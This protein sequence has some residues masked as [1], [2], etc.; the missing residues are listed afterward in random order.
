MSFGKP[1]IALLILATIIL[2]ITGCL[3]SQSPTPT[4]TTSTDATL[5][6]T[7][8]NTNIPSLTNLSSTPIITSPVFP[9]PTTT[10][11]YQAPAIIDKNS[12][13]Q[14]VRVNL[15]KFTGSIFSPN[16]IIMVNNVQATVNNDGSYYA[17]LDLAPGE[18]S[19]EVKT[20]ANQTIA[21]DHIT[22]TFR[23]PLVIILYWAS[24]NPSDSNNYTKVPMEINGIVSDPTA[25]VEINH[26]S[27]IV[28]TDGTF[29]IQTL[30]K[31]GYNPF[32][33]VAVLG[34]ETDI[35]SISPEVLEDGKLVPPPPG[36][37]ADYS[38]AGFNHGNPE[39]NIKVG[40]TILADVDILSKK[41]VFSGEQSPDLN[42]FKTNIIRTR[43]PHSN[44]PQDK[45]PMVSGLTV[46]FN[47]PTY[48]LFPKIEYHSLM[49][50]K[51]SAGL[52]PG[53][54]YFLIEHYIDGAAHGYSF[55]TVFAKP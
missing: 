41:D 35:G 46:D 28:N 23:P 40:D 17:Y 42:S 18:N 34:D 13:G 15:V 12:D 38:A 44:N 32:I 6:A 3:Q 33:A 1:A 22:V 50:I 47:P 52:I 16:T 19:I 37:G 43:Q 39:I 4:P 7:I 20:N 2:F 10:K 21:S 53:N 30:L 36:L 25:Q 5:T 9:E 55:I 51:T 54:Y 45:L 31:V 29:S 8:S 24:W 26:K 11:F 14:E 27:I 49:N 48:K